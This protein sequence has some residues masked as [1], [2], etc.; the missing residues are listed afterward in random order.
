MFSRAHTYLD[1][2]LEGES[3]QNLDLNP[4]SLLVCGNVFFVILLSRC[5]FVTVYAGVECN[6]EV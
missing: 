4:S 6:M 2:C 3:V 1:A 5:R